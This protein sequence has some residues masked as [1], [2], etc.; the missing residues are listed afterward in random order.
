MARGEDNVG[1]RKGEGPPLTSSNDV[2]LLVDFARVITWLRP[3]REHLE[4][5]FWKMF[6]FPPNV[7]VS[8]M[9]LGPCVAVHM[10]ED[11]DEMNI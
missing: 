6:S 11:H 3:V 7:R 8:S 9:S 1:S 10:D 2:P 5:A 4:D